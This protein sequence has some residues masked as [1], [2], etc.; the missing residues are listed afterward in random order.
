MGWA[1]TGLN[2]IKPVEV[3]QT[4]RISPDMKLARIPPA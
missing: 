3:E 1:R 4:Y 2:W